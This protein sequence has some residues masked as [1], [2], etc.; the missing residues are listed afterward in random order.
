MNALD[1][2]AQIQK[3]AIPMRLK[4]GAEIL[5]RLWQEGHHCRDKWSGTCSDGSAAN[6][7]CRAKLKWFTLFQETYPSCDFSAVSS[8]PWFLV[9]VMVVEGYWTETGLT[10]QVQMPGADRPIKVGPKGTTPDTIFELSSLPE[11]DRAAAVQ[12]VVKIQAVGL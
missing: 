11:H 3:A 2:I 9:E 6:D 1:R 8:C 12:A 4:K 7:F 5:G 10:A